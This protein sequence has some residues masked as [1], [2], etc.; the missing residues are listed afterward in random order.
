ME[1]LDIKG[2]HFYAFKEAY[3]RNSLKF[4]DKKYAALD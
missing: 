3:E 2:Y 4:R 1:R